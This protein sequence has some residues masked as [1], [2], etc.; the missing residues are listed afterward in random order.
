MAAGSIVALETVEI[1]VQ[2][3]K[4]KGRRVA[5]KGESENGLDSDLLSLETSSRIRIVVSVFVCPPLLSISHCF[6]DT[7]L[8]TPKNQVTPLFSF[9]P[10]ISLI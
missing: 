3:L 4:E 1:C 2:S 10:F 6:R 8:G 5:L 7:H 9:L